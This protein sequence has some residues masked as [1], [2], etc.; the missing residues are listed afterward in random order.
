M[1]KLMTDKNRYINR[2]EIET[3]TMDAPFIKCPK[4]DKEYETLTG[5]FS[6]DM[7]DLNG[8]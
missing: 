2:N 4:C 7:D 3:T 8:M 5:M 1:E 6:T